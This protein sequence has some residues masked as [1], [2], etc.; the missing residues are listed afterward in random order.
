MMNNPPKKYRTIFTGELIQLTALSIGGRDNNTLVDNNFALDGAGR[1]VIRGTGIVGTLIATARDL[2]PDGKI[3]ES[4]TVGAMT[5]REFYRDSALI[6]HNAHLIDETATDWHYRTC[7]GISQLTGAA[8]E[9]VLFDTETL[10]AGTRWHFCLEIDP[11]LDKDDAALATACHVLEKWQEV[12]CLLGRDVARGLGWLKLEKL[13]I[14]ELKFPEDSS[15]WPDATQT[16]R[17]ALSNLLAINGT[18]DMPTLGSILKR[19][20]VTPPFYSTQ[21][22]RGKITLQAEQ[23]A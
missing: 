8:A 15:R 20:N 4:I 17:D 12:G 10:P 9:G 11:L 21:F 13:Q 16:T 3:A 18:E 5:I 6:T 19:L 23:S 22:L 2:F 14:L 1:P 7:V